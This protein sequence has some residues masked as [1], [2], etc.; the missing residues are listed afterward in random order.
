[1]A[2]AGE[3]AFLQRFVGRTLTVLWESSRPEEDDLVWSGLTG[4]YLR[5][6]A[7]GSADLA[8]TLCPV[9]LVALVDGGLQGE[10]ETQKSGG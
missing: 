7:R 9:R 8:N 3:Q 1:V 2:S 5:V 6:Q 4:N 10:M